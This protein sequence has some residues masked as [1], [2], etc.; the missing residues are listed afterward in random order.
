MPR[1]FS[2]IHRRMDATQLGVYPLRFIPP[3]HER[4]GFDSVTDKNNKVTMQ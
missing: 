3:R 2:V 1:V 4:V